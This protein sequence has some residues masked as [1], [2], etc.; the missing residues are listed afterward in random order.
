MSAMVGFFGAPRFA[1]IG[2]V[3][4]TAMLAA[5]ERKPLRSN[6]CSFAYSSLDFPF[7]FHF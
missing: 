4:P 3:I 2:V 7:R 6:A 5:G 1:T